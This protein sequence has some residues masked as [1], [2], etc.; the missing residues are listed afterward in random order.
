MKITRHI[1]V[2]FAFVLSIAF[3][4]G[5][6]RPQSQKLDGSIRPE[7]VTPDPTTLASGD[8]CTITVTMDGIAASDTTVDVSS[9]NTGLVTVPATITVPSGSDQGVG[10]GSCIANAASQDVTIT[11][12]ANGGQAQG[13]VTVD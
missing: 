12:T 13:T 2:V 7:W 6:A 9:S 10:Y 1:L 11:A 8:Q 3:A 4:I 5:Y